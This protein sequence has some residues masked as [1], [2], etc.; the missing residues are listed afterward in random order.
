MDPDTWD[1]TGTSKDAN[2]H[3]PKE[4]IP[5]KYPY[6]IRVNKQANCVTIY[7]RNK[8]GEYTKP[9]KAMVCSAGSQTPLGTFNTS[10]KYY[11]KAM[12][13]KVWAQYA[14]RI[15]GKILFHS[16]PYD[17]P[18]KD[19][20]ITGY[21]NQ[22]GQ[23]ASAGCVR[24]SV[25]DAKW[26][27]ENCPAGTKVTIYNDANPG[28]LGKPTPIRIA[29]NCRWDPTDPDK[30][31]PFKSKRS[32]FIG[33][34]N[35]TIER[36]TGYNPLQEVIAYDVHSGVMSNDKIKVKTKLN[37]SKCGEYKVSLTFKDSKKKTIKKSFVITVKDTK[38]PVITGLPSTIYTKD[39]KKIT[40]SYIQ[41]KLK[42]A[43]NGYSLNKNSH[44]S[45][46]K[47]GNG[48]TAIAKDAY[49]HSS[50]LK[51]NV[52]E[53]SKAPEITVKAPFDNPL[54]ISTK[55]DK[56]WAKER[57]KN[58]SD[59]KTKLNKNDVSI[60]V[61]PRGWGMKIT[62][63]ATDSAGNRTT[64][65]E[66][67]SFETASLSI[68]SDNIIVNNVDSTKEMSKYINVTS[69]FTGKEVPYSLSIKSKQ[70]D[71]NDEF[72]TYNVTFNVTYKSSAGNK[73]L[74]ASAVVYETY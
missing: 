8:K 3:Y 45:I 32:T 4:D 58:V 23:T 29:S 66:T 71:A 5:K 63:S 64:L 41:N 48:Y 19:T 20:L 59:N 70:T 56:N 42:V 61:K 38:A 11:W 46:T 44:L 60:S 26:I 21:Y 9:V 73:K 65:S 27:I 35:R 74:S 2:M 37:T 47:S 69:D 50:T 10:N 14:T 31:N 54:P 22:L 34:K 55:I 49:G 39:A 13:H 12:I 53:D 28:P 43:D 15:T 51:I 62:Y 33:A 24:L 72:T 16:V 68:N 17:Y 6:E 57:I 67:V 36:G 40:T 18:D 30:R 25:A 1:Y 7:K 52:I